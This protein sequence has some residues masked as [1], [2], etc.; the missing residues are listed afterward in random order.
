MTGFEIRVP[1]TVANMGPGFDFL[2]MGA[3]VYL[4]MKVSPVSSGEGSFSFLIRG[5][6]IDLPPE[7]NIL[8]EALRRGA[9]LAGGTLPAAD[10]IVESGIPLKKGLGS[11]AAAR[12]AGVA[13][14]GMLCGKKISPE[15]AASEAAA[16]E[17]HPDNAFPA[18]L[19][20]LVVCARD[21]GR[22]TYCRVGIPSGVSLLI[23]I[24]DTEV[25]TGAAR[26]AMPGEVSLPDAVY[27]ASRAA[28]LVLFLSRG[29]FSRLP[30]V[31]SDRVH[32]PCR[33]RFIPAYGEI[34]ERALASGAWGV[35]ISGSGPSVLCFVPPGR[36]AEIEAAMKETWERAGTGS[37][38]I[39]T[40][41]SGTGVEIREL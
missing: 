31:M 19:G 17:G 8:P 39:E 30:E 36:G 23:G 5:N 11:S 13:A 1:A 35:A 41:V 10:I 22:V 2:G 9:A 25:D 7:K 32:E 29:E 37:E 21:E 27:S 33:G 38:F 3:G 18:A 40:S 26:A 16:L 14:G 4:S 24:P 15:E 12:V 20:S 34:R 6:R 28:M